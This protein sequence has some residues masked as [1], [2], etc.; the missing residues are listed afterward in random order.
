MINYLRQYAAR[1]SARK[2][3][4]MLQGYRNLKINDELHK[5]D[6]IRL[7]LLRQNIPIPDSQ[8]SK[9]LYGAS[10]PNAELI[11]RQQLAK[12]FLVLNKALLIALSRP[13][14]GVIAPLP[15]QFRSVISNQGFL[16]S[17][18][19]CG[20]LWHSYIGLMFI[21]G[22][23]K[24]ALIFFQGFSF[25]GIGEE[26]KSYV[27]FYNIS[28]GNIPYEDNQKSSCYNL[29]SW[30]LQLDGRIKKSFD[31][32]RHSV[33]GVSINLLDGILRYQSEPLPRGRGLVFCL[34]YF[35]WSVNAILKTF[36]D[37]I[38]GRWW[39]A[40]IL[41]EAAVS[42]KVRLLPSDLLAKQYLFNNSTHYPPLWTYEAEKLGS[43]ILFYFYSTNCEQFQRKDKTR[44]FSSLYSIMNWKSYLV[45]DNYQA[46][47]VAMCEGRNPKISVV[48]S[49]WFQDSPEDLPKFF[50]PGVA[51]FD[52]QPFRQSIVA[53][54]VAGVEY[55]PYFSKLFINHVSDVIIDCRASMLWK[56]KR[57]IGK[58]VD[59]KYVALTNSIAKKTQ[60]VI[61]NP[62]ISAVRVIKNSAAVISVPFTSTAL[63]AREMG[64]PSVY[65]DP[66]GEMDSNDLAAHGIPILQTPMELKKWLIATL[67]RFH[68]K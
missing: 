62:E 59:G 20:F 23:L 58:A 40:L 56:R 33:S 41:H 61:I 11:I 24:V 31:E 52:V 30:Y 53:M 1:I 45:W 34:K 4:K 67:D 22:F 43:E 46:K 18:W 36:S 26:K 29:I 49:I 6:D 12:R 51:V 60:V 7:I 21:Y 68:G 17:N 14:R 37:F 3:R 8:F 19:R 57:S 47:F 63:L 25:K 13:N 44:P 38:R 2:I 39:H 15:K 54:H 65:Y 35:Y 42:A 48:G 55:Y 50:S 28:K 10:F 32:I 9:I 64:V 5:I 66:S 27:Y 16:V